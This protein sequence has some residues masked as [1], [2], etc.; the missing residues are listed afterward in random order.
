MAYCPAC[1]TEWDPPVAKCPV[2][3]GELTAG[4][5]ESDWTLLGTIRDKVSADFA[6]EVLSSYEIPAVVISKSGFF[7]QV[8]LT[9]NTFYKAGSHMFEISVPT[10]HVLE[11]REIMN[12]AVGESWERKED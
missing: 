1:K 9:F 10:E 2:C 4:K 12:M 8:G 5:E 11:A 3:S 7:G 6:R